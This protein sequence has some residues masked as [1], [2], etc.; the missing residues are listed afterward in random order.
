M[1]HRALVFAS[2]VVALLQCPMRALVSRTT[3]S[4]KP[5]SRDVVVVVLL[6]AAVSCMAGRKEEAAGS[7]DL[8]GGD[9][10]RF[11]TSVFIEIRFLEKYRYRSVP[12]KNRYRRNSVSILSVRF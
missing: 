12:S 9:S 8:V 5:E 7:L 2:A 10:V 4:G 3:Q 1:G 11:V 6:A